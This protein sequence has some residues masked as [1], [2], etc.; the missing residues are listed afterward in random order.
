MNQRPVPQGMAEAIVD[1]L[2]LIHIQHHQHRGEVVAHIQTEV[3]LA[4]LEKETA[5]VESGETISYRLLVQLLLELVQFGDIGGDT[6]QGRGAIPQQKGHLDRPVVVLIALDIGQRLFS[7]LQFSRFEYPVVQPPQLAGAGGRDHLIIAPVD[8]LLGRKAKQ[9][10]DL[11]VDVEKAVQAVLHIDMGIH[12]GEDD[13]QQLMLL[14]HA[15]LNQLVFG[16]IGGDA[17]QTDQVAILVMDGLFNGPV[18]ALFPGGFEV[19]DL[20]L[21]DGELL[22]QY[23]P[24]VALNGVGEFEIKKSPIILPLQLDEGAA[25][26]I[27]HRLIGIGVT[28][29]QILGEHVGVRLVEDGFE[30]IQLML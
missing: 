13:F 9:I 22:L 11:L 15:G 14:R 28:A 7:G 1:A 23:Q 20:L 25:K 8:E 4:H 17:A 10:G 2:E 24:V 27:Q 5:I 21:G 6:D 18:A 12:V 30:V 16:D 26:E 29:R 19:V 3:L